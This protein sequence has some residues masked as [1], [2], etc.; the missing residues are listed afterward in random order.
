MDIFNDQ[1]AR[2]SFGKG[3]QKTPRIGFNL[4]QDGNYDLSDKILANVAEGTV[5][6]D[7]ITKHQLDTTMIDKHYNN[8]DIDLNQYL[9]RYKQQTTNLQ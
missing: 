2:Q 7:A 5:S 6:N 3:I 1:S 8:Q 4:T 9:Q